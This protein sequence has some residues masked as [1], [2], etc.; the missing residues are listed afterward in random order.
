MS[1]H[2]LK[3]AVKLVNLS[4]YLRKHLQ[5]IY[6]EPID[7]GVLF[8]DGRIVVT[9][10]ELLLNTDVYYLTLLSCL[11]KDLPPSL[12]SSIKDQKSVFSLHAALENILED[13]EDEDLEPDELLE[14]FNVFSSQ[15][16]MFIKSK[17]EEFDIKLNQ[18]FIKIRKQIKSDYVD[19]YNDVDD[20]K[21]HLLDTHFK[22]LSTDFAKIVSEIQGQKDE[23][24]SISQSNQYSALKELNKDDPKTSFSEY[25][26]NLTKQFKLGCVGSFE[27]LDNLEKFLAKNNL[28]PDNTIFGILAKSGMIANSSIASFLKYNTIAVEAHGVSNVI[29]PVHYSFISMMGNLK[30]YDLKNKPNKLNGFKKFISGKNVVLVDNV[31]H[32]GKTMEKAADYLY[33]LGVT[34]IFPVAW[35]GRGGE[36]T[37]S[38]GNKKVELLLPNE[39]FSKI[40][41]NLK[42]F[43]SYWE[44]GNFL[45][46]HNLLSS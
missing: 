26:I 14:K 1:R 9:K 45:E 32:S 42:N 36:I 22:N 21:K 4:K 20:L 41:P 11:E 29:T 10:S 12:D 23:I 31:I 46:L 39:T 15:L 28:N 5:K 43:I 2:E 16:D 37:T 3:T 34:N 8:D 40:D 24:M 38:R 13:L 19:A 6:G 7:F 25:I 33:S 18:L 44:A 27:V 30:S 17:T 35:N